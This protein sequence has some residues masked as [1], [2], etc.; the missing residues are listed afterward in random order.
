MVITRER[1]VLA[2]LLLREV[3]LQVQPAEVPV[4]A[5]GTKAAKA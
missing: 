2:A 3:L 1:T 5:A 4:A